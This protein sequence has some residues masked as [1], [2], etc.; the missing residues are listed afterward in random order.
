MRLERR[1]RVFSSIITA[2]MLLVDGVMSLE[3]GSELRGCDV[4]ALVA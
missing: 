2:G 1:R 3:G 4:S